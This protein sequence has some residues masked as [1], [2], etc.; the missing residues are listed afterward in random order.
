M[1]FQTPVSQVLR[2]KGSSHVY[3]VRPTA[4][5]CE[6]AMLMQEK[7]IGSVL[8]VENNQILG[9]LNERDCILK[10][11]V[12]WISS[13]ETEVRDIMQQDVVTVSPDTTVNECFTIMTHGRIRHLPVVQNGIILGLV[14]IG[15][16]VRALVEDQEF[17]I[18]QLVNY[19]TGSHGIHATFF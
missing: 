18:N 11:L 17:L 5:I 8:V 12:P 3:T 1:I 10:V 9:I 14:S 19:V 7:A 6:A 13:A 2:I 4:S 15:D 16:I